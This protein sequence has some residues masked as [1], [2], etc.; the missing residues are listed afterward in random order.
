MP[1]RHRINITGAA[2]ECGEQPSTTTGER[3][4]KL[5]RLVDYL[6]QLFLAWSIQL[7]G[8]VSPGP[9]VAL[10]L[11]VAMSQ[12][13]LPSL[14]T[15]LGVACGSIILS[16]GTV[17]G[18]VSIFA[19]IADLMT[20]VR[21]IGAAYLAWLAYKAFRSAARPLALDLKEVP[22]QGPWRTGLTGFFLQISNP[23]AIFFWLAIAGV[24]GLADAPWPVIAIFVVG[25]FINSFAGH[26]G[27][28]LLLSSLPMRRAYARAKIWIEGSLGCFFLFASYKLATE[29]A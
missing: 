12:G 9:S 10:I 2:K 5:L 3:G 16:L 14:V 20:V 26:G 29:R 17:L 27:Y 15:A 1:T 24:G 25:A 7:M 22:Q 21:W 23:K 11:R 13:R 19:Q 28:A 8:V 4:N 18:M 6:P